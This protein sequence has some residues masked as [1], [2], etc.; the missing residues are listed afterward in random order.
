MEGRAEN[1]RLLI[2]G[3]CFP[4]TCSHPGP[5]HKSP[6]WN[7]RHFCHL[8]NYKGFRKPCV[9]NRDQRPRCIFFLLLHRWTGSLGQTGP[10]SAAWVLCFV[11]LLRL[12]VLLSPARLKL[13]QLR[14]CVPAWEGREACNMVG[15][16]ITS[17]HPRTRSPVTTTGENLVR[18]HTETEWRQADASSG[19][20]A[21]HP[22]GTLLLRKNGSRFWAM[23]SNLPQLLNFWI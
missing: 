7:K 11:A 19:W 10:L 23:S 21:A 8:G 2:H 9:S 4:I 1:C 22:A 5:H 17:T 20:A 16:C 3:L 12:S 6:Y 13:P 18:D 15:A 14:V